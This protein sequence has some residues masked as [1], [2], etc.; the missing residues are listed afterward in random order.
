MKLSQRSLW[1]TVVGASAVG[2]VAS[3]VQAIERIQFADDPVTKLTCDLNAVFSCS[4][5]FDA[6][7]SSVFGFSNSL[8]SLTFF[9][10]MVGVGLA[11]A[12]GSTLHRILRYVFHFFSV[13]FLLFGA[14]YLW[15]STYVIGY[16]CIFCLFN[17][18]GVIVLNWAWFRLQYSELR[19]KK[20][21][22]RRLDAFVKA[23]GDIMVAITW[24]LVFAV[25]MITHFW[26]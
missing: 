9:A 10:V 1:W 23:G 3:L 13:F 11:A 14:W 22:R 7:Q 21:A 26:M 19:L 24:A 2:L 17:Y 16:L 6:W 18:A 15:Q 20:P 8:V 25:M 5:V 4:N 12:S